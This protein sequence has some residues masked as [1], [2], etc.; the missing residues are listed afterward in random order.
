MNND[1][2]KFA[3]EEIVYLR[4]DEDAKGIITGILYTPIGVMYMVTWGIGNEQ[5][6][7]ASEI[8]NEKPFAEASK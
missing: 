8:T 1:T 3:L 6:H 5:R 7:Y 4:I 2:V